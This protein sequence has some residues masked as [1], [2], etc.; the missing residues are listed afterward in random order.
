MR[1]IPSR[2][3][4]KTTAAA[5]RPAA[6]GWLM[7][8]AVPTA[9]RPALRTSRQ[10]VASTPAAKGQSQARTPG[11]GTSRT[12][13]REGDPHHQG[14]HAQLAH[15]RSRCQQTRATPT[16]LAPSTWP[17]VPADPGISR[18]PAPRLFHE[19][20]LIVMVTAGA[21]LH[22]APLQSLEELPGL[23]WAPEARR[24]IGSSSAAPANLCQLAAQVRR[25]ARLTAVRRPTRTRPGR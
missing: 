23:S 13:V 19:C 2:T 14:R 17:A 18:R 16:S 15:G 7:V 8:P 1:Q 10:A 12:D 20:P 6:V 5:A 24:R 11:P 21:C 9:G 22:R 3:P 4:G 25:A